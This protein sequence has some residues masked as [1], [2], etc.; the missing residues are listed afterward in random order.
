MSKRFEEIDLVRGLALMVMIIFHLAFDAAFFLG[1]KI[2]VFSGYWQLIARFVQ[3]VFMIT[4][5]IT[6]A[7]RSQKNVSS[8]F[9]HAG[10]IFLYAMLITFVTWILFK[11]QAVYFGILHFFAVAIVLAIPLVRFGG[12][13]SLLGLAILFISYFFPFHGASSSVQPLDYFPLLPWFGVFLQGVAIGCV[14]YKKGERDPFVR[15]T[16]F[17]PQK[18]RELLRCM[19]RRS[20]LVY[21]IHQPILVGLIYLVRLFRS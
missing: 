4:T 18:I 12:W 8:Q 14:V 3:I 20:L 16:S 2:D 17:V 6:V 21:L 19:G 1:L 13:N 9:L 11:D 7:F 5:G 15:G 10:K